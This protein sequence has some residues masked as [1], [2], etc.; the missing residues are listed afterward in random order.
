MDEKGFTG[1]ARAAL[2]YAGKALVAGVLVGVFVLPLLSGLP[3]SL[4]LSLT[5]A[6]WAGAV[7]APWRRLV[8]AEWTRG[9]ALRQATRR[10][11]ALAL[12]IA[13]CGAV[14]CIASDYW[15]GTHATNGLGR[16]VIGAQ[17]DLLISAPFALL[18]L[19]MLATG[20]SGIG[21]WLTAAFVGFVCATSYEAVTSS[22]SSTAAIGLL[23]PWFIGVP[24]VFVGYILDVSA[25]GAVAGL[26]QRR[27]RRF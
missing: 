9:R 27:L 11:R 19:V 18:A 12:A 24:S 7:A 16:Q 15:F 25:R 8:R 6:I 23:G 2:R 21:A 1:P 5:L 26:R 10:R 22:S 17:W 14:L 13:V 4:A 3:M 20:M